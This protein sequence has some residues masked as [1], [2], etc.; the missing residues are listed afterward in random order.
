LA[1]IPKNGGFAGKP[2]FWGFLA[3]L[4]PFE[5]WFYINLSRRGPAVPGGGGEPR[6]GSE[7][8]P[9]PPSPGK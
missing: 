6:R 7:G 4:G 1:K 5:R 8:S 3:L 9:L 2:P